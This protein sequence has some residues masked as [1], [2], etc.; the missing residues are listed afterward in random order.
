LESSLSQLWLVGSSHKH[1][2][3]EVRERIWCQAEALPNRLRSILRDDISATEA[4]ILSTC[5]RT[6]VYVIAPGNNVEASLAARMSEWS[7]IDLG[8]LKDH[9]YSLRGKEVVDHLFAVASGLDSLVVGEPQIRS[10]VRRAISIAIQTSTAGPLLVHLFHQA[11]RTA[12]KAQWGANRADKA[13]VSTAAIALLKARLGEPGLRSILLI[14]AGK[15][16]TLAMQNLAEGSDHSR[17]EVY[18]ANRT[19]ERAEGLV[20]RFDGKPLKLSDIPRILGTVDAVLSCVSALDYVIVAKEVESAVSSRTTPLTIVDI[21]VPRSVDPACASIQG[22]QLH[23]IDDLAPV[24]ENCLSLAY[25]GI[26]EVER[27]VRSE[28]ERFCTRINA[29]RVVPTIR[30]L[31]KIAELVRSKELSRSLRRLNGISH[32]DKE[33]IELLTQRIVNKLLHEPTVRL[34]LHSAGGNGRRYEEAIRELFALREDD[35]ER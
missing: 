25:S 2:P 23:N 4:A 22:V 35:R 18:V 6:E 33:I 9:V 10:Q 12:K 24:L 13:S 30:E 3:I 14:G 17:F 27:F 28:A 26:V 16:I 1:A 11:C 34:R 7:G 32:R 8:V 15:M 21:S 29:Q 19:V 20:R 5:N 31:R